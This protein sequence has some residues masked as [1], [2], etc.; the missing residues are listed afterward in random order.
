MTVTA[1]Q[2][3]LHPD[4]IDYESPDFA[5]FTGLSRETLAKRTAT[6]SQACARPGTRSTTASSTRVKPGRKRPA[7]GWRPSA[8]TPC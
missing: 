4:A 8:T 2:I 5:Q 6:T 1:I 7:R 3:G